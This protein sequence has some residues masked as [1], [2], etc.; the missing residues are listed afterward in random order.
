[1]RSDCL[2]WYV[3]D[4]FIIAKYLAKAKHKSDKTDKGAPGI[5]QEMIQTWV[6]N[7]LVKVM[8][9]YGLNPEPNDHLESYAPEIETYIHYLKKLQE[10]YEDKAKAIHELL[11]DCTLYIGVLKKCSFAKVQTITWDVDI[12]SMLPIL[13][14]TWLRQLQQFFIKQEKRT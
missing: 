1:V 13:V 2:A 7:E 14:V 9:I 4:A 3:S 10:D 6:T 8:Y 11:H 5:Y 12:K